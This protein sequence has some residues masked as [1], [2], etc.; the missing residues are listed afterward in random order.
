MGGYFESHQHPLLH[1]STHLSPPPCFLKGSDLDYGTW[2]DQ[3]EH[4]EDGSKVFVLMNSLKLLDNVIQ[5][6]G[7]KMLVN[8]NAQTGSNK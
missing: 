7:I 2:F 6:H 4:E 3:V 5:Y 1:A 8:K